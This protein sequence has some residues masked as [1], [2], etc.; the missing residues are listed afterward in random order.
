MTRDSADSPE[1]L[2]TVFDYHRATK[3]RFQAYA[4]GPGYLEWATQPDPFRRY[5]GAR[6]I[7]L[8][9][10]PPADEP[11]YDAV[12]DPGRRPAP[13]AVN[14]QTV[15]QLFYDSLALSV[16]KSL[17]DTR[18]ALRVNAS[19]GNLHPTEGYLICG[20]VEGLCDTPV[21]CHYAP[22]AHGLEVL[23]EFDAPHWRALSTRF[24]AQTF[25]MGLTSIHWREA[26]KYGQRAY[27][28]CMLDALHPRIQSVNWHS[29]RKRHS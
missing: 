25:F 20:P 5:A 2:Q 10:V 13:A 6:L 3:H 4:R 15:S 29:F 21:V 26:W 11:G 14:L 18:W 19:S 22:Q 9:A 24:P 8:Q 16:W 7:A 1:R 23:A 12:F 17:G 28:Y 27:R